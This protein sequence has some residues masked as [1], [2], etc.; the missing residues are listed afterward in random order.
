MPIE[1]VAAGTLL[2]PF[3]GAPQV[4]FRAAAATGPS[5]ATTTMTRVCWFYVNH[6]G[7]TSRFIIDATNTNQDGWAFVVL[8]TPNSVVL[9]VQSP[10]GLGAAA[11]PWTPMRGL[12]IVLGSYDGVDVR[13]RI[14]SVG[15]ASAGYAGVP[16]GTPNRLAVGAFAASVTIDGNTFRQGYVG[17]F[18]AQNA[19]RIDPA[20]EVDYLDTV[21]DDLSQG[22]DVTLPD[23]SAGGASDWY[24]DARDWSALTSWNDR[25]NGYALVATGSPQRAGAAM[26][27]AV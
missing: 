19:F 7:L 22:R 1:R 18:I 20:D 15:V 25:I 27:S 3:S 12:F 11:V 24:F 17:G 8:G 21:L 16:S 13:C 14:R 23:G 2:G 26:R 9:R 4:N 5:L 6:V 10:A